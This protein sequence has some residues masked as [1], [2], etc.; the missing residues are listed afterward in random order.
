MGPYF[1]LWCGGF[2]FP[3]STFNPLCS[4]KQTR[5]FCQ[6]ITKA[7]AD[8]KHFAESQTSCY[9]PHFI[10]TALGGRHHVSVLEMRRLWL[11]GVDLLQVT[12]RGTWKEI[13]ADSRGAL[14]S[15]GTIPS[16]AALVLH[17]CPSYTFCKVA[18]GPAHWNHLGT[19]KTTDGQVW[20]GLGSIWATGFFL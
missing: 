11:W 19:F 12:G 6:I 8:M 18:L 9:L 16:N 15:E 3:L 4:I 20:S 17:V 14:P 1:T 5:R 2:V 7:R 10:L 13:Q